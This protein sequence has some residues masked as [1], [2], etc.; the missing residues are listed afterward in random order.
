MVGPCRDENAQP[1][2]MWNNV[3]GNVGTVVSMKFYKARFAEVRDRCYTILPDFADG[4]EPNLFRDV[5]LPFNVANDEDRE[6]RTQLT[7]FQAFLQSI[8]KKDVLEDTRSDDFDWKTIFN[9]DVKALDEEYRLN[10]RARFSTTRRLKMI[11][12]MTSWLGSFRCYLDIHLGKFCALL[13]LSTLME[14][15][16]PFQLSGGG[17]RLTDK[18]Y[19]SHSAVTMTSTVRKTMYQISLSL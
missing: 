19:P 11:R 6:G 7:L 5:N 9:N 15:L 13:W 3:I 17:F 18:D 4:S 2:T 10:G 16:L 12:M 1:V 14:E 8:K